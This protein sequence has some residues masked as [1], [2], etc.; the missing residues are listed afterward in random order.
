MHNDNREELLNLPD[1]DF[2]RSITNIIA[3][4]HNG[5]V[6]AYIKNLIETIDTLEANMERFTIDFLVDEF[7]TEAN[8]FLTAA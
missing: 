6:F 5:D 3:E 1:S 7:L 8:E 2:R 4:K